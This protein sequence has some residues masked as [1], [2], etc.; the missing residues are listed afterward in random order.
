MSDASGN[1]K[2]IWGLMDKKHKQMFG[3]TLTDRIRDQQMQ[4]LKAHNRK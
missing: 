3:V 1:P 4:L 2:T